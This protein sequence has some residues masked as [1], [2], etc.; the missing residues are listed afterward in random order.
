MADPVNSES[1][2]TAPPSTELDSSTQPGTEPE[3][4][5]EQAPLDAQAL[6][7]RMVAAGEWPEPALLE[8]IIEA[9]DAAVAPLISVVRTYPR[10]WPEEAPLNHA[11][12]MLSILRRPAAIPE[13]IEIIRRYGIETGELAAESFGSFGAVA[14]EPLFSVCR[15]QAVTGYARIN[16]ITAALGAA[17]DD[18]ALRARLADV[19]RPILADVIERLRQQRNAPKAAAA[20]DLDDETDEDDSEAG[21][22]EVSKIEG[23]QDDDQSGEN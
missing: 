4:A 14:F 12:A 17:G 1:T 22:A 18:Q 15:D 8:K 13:L 7:D 20:D 16:A 11:M 6:V 21:L 2:A 23:D 19:V 9:G 10:G 5:M 3:L